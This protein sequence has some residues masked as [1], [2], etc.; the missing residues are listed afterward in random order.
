MKNNIFNILKKELREV[1]RDKKSISMMLIIPFMIP[2]L[3]IGMSALFDSQ[4][5]VDEEQYNK[6]GFTY[7]LSEAEISILDEM[8]IDYTVGTEDKIVDK[9][10]SGEIYLYITK[11]GRIYNIN[12]DDGNDYSSLAA[13]L[14]EGYLTTYKTYLQTEYL[15]NHD[16]DPGEVTNIIQINFAATEE[17]DNFFSN[18]IT[19]YAFMFIIMAITVSATYPSTDATAGEKERGTLETLLTFP[20]KSKDIIIGKLLS[21]TTTSIITGALSLLL[22]IISLAI[23]NKNFVIY[24]GL[25]IV[26]NA[27]C[28]IISIIIIILYSLFISGL[29][30]AI[31]SKSKSFKEAQS[32]LTPLTFISFFPSMVAFMVNVETS[33]VLSIVPFLNFTLIFTDINAGNINIVNIIAMIISTLIYISVI[34]FLIV[35]QYKSEEVLFKY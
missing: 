32:A 14:A 29:C 4:V 17:Q 19:V 30:L 24:E 26:P 31:A 11:E 20:I 7:E 27:T 28:I 10:D 6:I 8:N 15:Y 9:Y 22:A 25:N 12:Y 21:V 16:V 1:F 18:Y 33:T 5:N 13:T 35:K 23:A 3:V 2:L 34:I